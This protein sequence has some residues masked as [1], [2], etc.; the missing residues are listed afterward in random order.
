M[1]II[2]KIIQGSTPVFTQPY[3]HR[4]RV[5]NQQPI[6]VCTYRGIVPR[7]QR[8]TA[9]AK[10]WVNLQ[11]TKWGKL[12]TMATYCMIP[13]IEATGK[14]REQNPAL[15]RQKLRRARHWTVLPHS[16]ARILKCLYHGDSTG[17][18]T[19]TRQGGNDRGS[20]CQVPPFCSGEMWTTTRLASAPTCQIGVRERPFLF[21]RRD[22]ICT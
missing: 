13:F 12:E 21:L 6:A 1:L 5:R 4:P 15:G 7:H 16:N 9:T 22:H 19:N 10:R 2:I 20:S 3:S 14:S 11:V 17:N 8:K 18:A